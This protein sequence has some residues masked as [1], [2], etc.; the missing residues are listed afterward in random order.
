MESDTTDLRL[1]DGVATFLNLYNPVLMRQLLDPGVPSIF[2]CRKKVVL[3]ESNELIIKRNTNVVTVGWCSEFMTDPEIINGMLRKGR[4]FRDYDTLVKF[5]IQP[6]GEWT[7]MCAQD[8]ITGHELTKNPNKVERVGTKAA[9]RLLMNKEWMQERMVTI[10]TSDL[11]QHSVAHYKPIP[12]Q[13]IQDPDF[14]AYLAADLVTMATPQD[15]AVVEP[16]SNTLPDTI[17]HNRGTKTHITQKELMKHKTTEAPVIADNAMNNLAFQTSALNFDDIKTPITKGSS[18]NA[19]S[20]E[21]HVAKAPVANTQ[22]VD[23]PDMENSFWQ[24]NAMLNNDAKANAIGK[25]P[26]NAAGIKGR[27]AENPVRKSSR[28]KD[29]GI[30]EYEMEDLDQT[31]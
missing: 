11:L 2:F 3:H 8:E 5:C 15:Y 21:A 25:N 26:A 19:S 22:V 28:A 9:R 6:S 24:A 27:V 30:E 12:D 14:R 10:T 23:T 17:T 18:V 13:N 7:P 20:P 29:H 1:A 4:L 16:H 31:L